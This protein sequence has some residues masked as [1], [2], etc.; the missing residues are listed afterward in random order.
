MRLIWLLAKRTRKAT[1]K[2]SRPIFLV[3]MEHYTRRNY[4]SFGHGLYFN[5]AVRRD[6]SSPAARALPQHC[7]APRLLVTRPHRLYVNLTVRREYSFSC[8]SGSTSTTP[9]A[10][11]TSSSRRTT[12]STSLN[13]KTSRGRLPRHQQLVGSTSN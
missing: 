7:R 2:I 10:I 12:T 3:H 4:S 9:Y 8:R 11:A 1:K 5:F 6:Y 13:Q